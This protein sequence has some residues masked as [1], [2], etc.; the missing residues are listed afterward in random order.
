MSAIIWGL[1][2]KYMQ[3]FI[4]GSIAF[5][6]GNYSGWVKGVERERMIQANNY[7]AMIA[8]QATKNNAIL[9]KKESDIIELTNQKNELMG[10]LQ[11]EKDYINSN[12]RV[13][14]NFVRIT[15]APSASKA[16]STITKQGATIPEFESIPASRIAEYIIQLKAH[17]D[18]CVVMQNA[19]IDSVI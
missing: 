19:L 11:R 10:D 8:E 2:N 4:V 7:S 17:D 3:L 5:A 15:S 16:T 14:G 13:Y 12:N 1:R 9:A 18:N 6:Y